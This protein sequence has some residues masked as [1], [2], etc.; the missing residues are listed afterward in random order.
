MP[1]SAETA[2]RV[3]THIVEARLQASRIIDQA[4]RDLSFQPVSEVL[5]SANRFLRSAIVEALPSDSGKLGP[6]ILSQGLKHTLRARL[7]LFGREPDSAIRSEITKLLAV[8]DPPAL[9]TSKLPRTIKR[10]SPKP[11]ARPRSRDAVIRPD[12][13]PRNIE[14]PKHGMDD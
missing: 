2:A 7:S 1:D 4:V 10:E 3:T 11:D 12:A 6:A 13:R 8:I 14:E 5:P 9:R